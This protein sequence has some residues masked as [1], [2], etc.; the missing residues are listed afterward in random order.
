MKV[1]F[2]G[3]GR[4]DPSQQEAVFLRVRQCAVPLQAREND[5]GIDFESHDR[6]TKVDSC[7][8]GGKAGSTTL[9]SVIHGE[10]EK[11]PRGICG[12]HLR[13]VSPGIQERG[14]I[15]SLAISCSASSRLDWRENDAG[16]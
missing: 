10:R 4:Q 2:G 5:V 6:F 7:S 16:Q 9:L 14:P 11:A 13:K 8:R 15:P 1:A 12:T 3:L